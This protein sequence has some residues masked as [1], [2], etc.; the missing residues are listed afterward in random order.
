MVADSGRGALSDDEVTVVFW[1]AVKNERKVTV[2]LTD[3]G[4]D[5]PNQLRPSQRTGEFD[6][7]TVRTSVHGDTHSKY[8]SARVVDGATSTEA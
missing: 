6:G 4:F 1:G 3:K 2:A 8:L 7:D 5:A